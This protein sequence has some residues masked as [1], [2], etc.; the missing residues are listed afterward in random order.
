[1]RAFLAV[2]LVAVLAL[3]TA[4]DAG[5][6]IDNVVMEVDSGGRATTEVTNIGD[7]PLGYVLTPYEWTVEDGEDVYRET[8]QFMAVPPSFQLAPGQSMTVRVGLRNATPAQIER[9]WRLSVRE[10]PTQTAEEGLSLAFN[11]MLPVYIAP[12]GGVQPPNLAWS[13]LRDGQG[14][15]VRVTN[16]GNRRQVIERLTVGGQVIETRAR[17]TVLANS[18]R[19]FRVADAD[20]RSGSVQLEVRYLSGG[21]ESLSLRAD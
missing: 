21:T 8:G 2:S 4:T 9:T 12:R 1:M 10:V 18:W 6:R 13:L 14:W 3:G 11:H 5:T 7:V 15:A 17:S 16:D 19:Q 20:V